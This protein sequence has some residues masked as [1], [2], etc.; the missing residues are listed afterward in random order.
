MLVYALALFA[1]AAL[2]GVYMLMRVFKGAMPPLQAAFFHGLFAATGLVLL[3]YDAFFAGP[4]APLAVTV[5]AVILVLAAC[6]G[7][8]LL[9]YQL[10]G[11]A[12]PKTLAVVHALLAVCGF[13]TLGG[14]VLGLI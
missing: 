3:L 9:S 1:L 10:R 8:L 4:M 14:A 7:F 11:Q 6:G 12:P 13:L 2:V 5:A